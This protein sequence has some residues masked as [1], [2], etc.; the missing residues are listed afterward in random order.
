[1]FSSY[2]C[3]E[4][5]L[6]PVLSRYSILIVDEA[7]ER[8]VHTDV[9]LGLLKDVQKARLKLINERDTNYKNQSNSLKD[10]SLNPNALKQ[11]QGR[12][13]SPLKLIVMS[14]SLDARVFSDYF[15]GAK[16]VHVEGRQHPVDI[17]YTLHPQSDYL[18]AALTSIFQVNFAYSS[19]CVVYVFVTVY[20][21]FHQHLYM[22]T[23][24]R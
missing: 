17:L 13:L 4:A 22:I 3:R 1:M 7:H 5:L 24:I 10:D 20:I 9:L 23:F 6:D 16:A 14:A 2:T 8:T 15:G 11:Y 19:I 12:K 21:N 18:E